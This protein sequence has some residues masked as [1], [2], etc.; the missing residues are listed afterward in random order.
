M[1]YEDLVNDP[2]T[3]LERLG[4]FLDFDDWRQ[5]AHRVIGA[6]QAPAR[7]RGV[8]ARAAVPAAPVAESASTS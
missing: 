8:A 7:T 2:V 4:R 1:R 6:V 5:W 3:Q